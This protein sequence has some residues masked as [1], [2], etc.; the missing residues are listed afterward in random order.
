MSAG[1]GADVRHLANVLGVVALDVLTQMGAA[2]EDA[3]GLSSVQA[4]AV[5]ALANSS[6]GGS[7]DDLR[8][9]VDLSHSA[10]VRLVDRLVERGLVTRRAAVDGRVAAVH[11]TA[12]GRRTAAAIRQARQAVLEDL[13]G[14]LPVEQR[15]S[16]TVVLDGMAALEVRP[17][18]EGVAAADYLCRLCDPDACGFPRRCPVTKAVRAEDR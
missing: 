6:D 5:S 7:T 2:I 11:L 10:T 8:R 1:R 12:R 16:L 18:P 14:H 17:A 4:T 15:R 13:V 3:T 9:I